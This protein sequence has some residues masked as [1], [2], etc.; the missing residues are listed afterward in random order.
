[1]YAVGR[2]KSATARVR[3]YEGKQ[4]E[5]DNGQLEVNGVSHETYFSK[6]LAAHA[7]APLPLIAAP[8]DGYFTVKVEGGGT[9]AQAQAVAHGIARILV[10]INAEWK[11][12]L[13][14][15]GFVRRDPRTKERKKP[16]LRR[17]RRAPQWSKR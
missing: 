8:I 9:S 16:G 6:T 10:Q 14:Q 13:K 17:A 12:L 1:M 4:P 7:M 15:K 3:F 5:G 2:R 11:P